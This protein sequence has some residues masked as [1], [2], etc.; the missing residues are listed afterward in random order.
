MTAF[1]RLISGF[2][3]NKIAPPIHGDDVVYPLHILDDNKTLHNFVVA[4][5]LRFDDVLDVE[6]LNNSLSRLM[7]IDDW[8]MLGGRLRL[9]VTSGPLNPL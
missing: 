4:W 9:K 6:K 8:R 2:T 3:G 1:L 7:E 5:T